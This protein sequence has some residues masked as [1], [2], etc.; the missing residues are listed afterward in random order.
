M[1]IPEKEERE[2]GPEN[3]FKEIVAYRFLKWGRKQIFRPMR[4][5]TPNKVNKS[6]PIASTTVIKFL[7]YIVIKKKN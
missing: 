3:L 7:S 1:R 4:H 5:R 6:R 2:K